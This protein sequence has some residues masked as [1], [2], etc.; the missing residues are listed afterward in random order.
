[1]EV[2]MSERQY[3]GVEIIRQGRPVLDPGA[4]GEQLPAW[5]CPSCNAAF[6]LTAK[7]VRVDEPPDIV[8]TFYAIPMF[9]QVQARVSTLCPDCDTLITQLA[10]RS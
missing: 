10:P 6:R 4:G 5:E 3:E 1:M 7:A 9:E 2:Q 8:G